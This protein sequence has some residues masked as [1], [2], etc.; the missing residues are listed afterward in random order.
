MQLDCGNQCL[1]M[2]CTHVFV[3][4]QAIGRTANGNDFG[5]QF[6]KHFGSDL[7]G[8]AMGCIDH[9]S[10]ALERKLIAEGALTKLDVAT[11]S[12]IQTLGFAQ[13]SRCD[14]DGRFVDQLF[15]RKLPIICELG[16]FGTEKLDAIVVIGIV[17]GT[18][19]HPQRSATG[20]REVSDCGCGHRTQQHHINACRVKGRLQGAFKHVA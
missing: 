15:N 19:H 2:R 8:R 10:H 12:I 13:L 1:R 9:N 6:V 5:T 11:R 3:D 4:V 18:D 14:P 16:A 7:I 17:A 20:T